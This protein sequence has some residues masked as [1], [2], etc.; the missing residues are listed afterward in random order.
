MHFFEFYIYWGAIF[1]GAWGGTGGLLN[2]EVDEGLIWGEEN[3]LLCGTE[4]LLIIGG[5]GGGKPLP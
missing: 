5:G 2:D 1:G 4:I 3:E